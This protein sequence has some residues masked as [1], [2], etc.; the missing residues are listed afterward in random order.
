MDIYNK[1]EQSVLGLNSVDEKFRE[2]LEEAK[3]YYEFYEGRVN[4]KDDKEDNRGQL[5]KVNTDDYTPTREIRN[6]TKKLLKKQ[7]RFMTSVKP[8]LIIKSID[9]ANIDRVDNKKA[10]INKILSDGG[11]WNK[12][13]KAFLDCTI[14]KRVMLCLITDIDKN[15][16]VLSENPIKFRFYTIP[17]FIY[18]F[19]PNDCE[20]L[21]KVQIAYQ[22]ET[23]IGNIQQEQRWHRW[24]YEMKDDECWAT[25]QVVD[26]VGTQAFIEAVNEDTGEKEKQDIKESW[27]T[28]L[29]QIPC[30]V[31]FNDPTTGDIKGHSDIKDLMDMA[32]DYNRTVS[33]YRDALKFRMFEQDVFV[34]ADPQSIDNIKIA[35]GS[36]VDLKGDPAMGSADGSIPTPSY[37]KLASSFNFQ[38]AADSYLNAL[39]KDMY[40]IMDQPLPESLVNVA[41]GKALR[42]LNDDLIARCE[43]KWQEWDNA[44]YWLINL[45]IEAV[46]KFKLYR[47]VEGIE[48]LNLNTSLN[49]YHNYPIPD[50]EIETKTL[51]MKEVEANVRSHQSY[52]RDFGEAQEADKEFEEILEEQDKINMTLNGSSGLND[53]NLDTEDDENNEDGEG[54]EY[55]E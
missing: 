53:F 33:D 7:K 19:D 51:A 14:G 37:G 20:K 12:F 36:M 6:I 39:K 16:N 52:I 29:S 40:E 24:T 4:L 10:I 47:D 11:F 50:D 23:T 54:S 21:I 45:I 32:M 5:W 48:D 44:L 8:D 34:N 9:G 30:K 41:S 17:E 43:E 28:G 49:I 22:D 27:N 55:D 25:Y 31:I 3:K 13:S 1:I 38:S 35:P 46:D 26:G 18:E 42:M 15:N 2:E